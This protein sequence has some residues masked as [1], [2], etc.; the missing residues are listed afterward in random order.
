MRALLRRGRRAARF[1]VVLGLAAGLVAMA[2]GTA[3]AD[4]VPS[5]WNVNFHDFGSV[6]S[7][8]TF[9]FTNVYTLPLFGQPMKFL[10]PE[11]SVTGNTCATPV[12]PGGTCTVKVHYTADGQ[13]VADS[14]QMQFAAPTGQPVPTPPVQLFAGGVAYVKTRHPGGVFTFPTSTPPASRAAGLRLPPFQVEYLTIQYI[15]I[16]LIIK[17]DIPPDLQAP[18]FVAKNTCTSP[19]TAACKV[20]LGFAPAA[21]GQYGSDFQMSFENAQTGASLPTQDVT[22]VGNAVAGAR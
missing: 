2:A 11:F 19:G 3:Q 5:P 12:N 20:V 22:L 7:S 15:G 17:V 9:V 4:P 13:P 8:H 1:P 14:L 6:S 18:F 21:A 16:P 10:H